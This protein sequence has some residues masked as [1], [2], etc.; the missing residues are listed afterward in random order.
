MNYDIAMKWAK[1]LESGRYTQG[2][3]YLKQ[4]MH[5]DRPRLCCLGV[6]CEMG[7][8]A[9]VEVEIEALSKTW[10]YDEQAQCL[11]LSIREWSGVSSETGVFKDENLNDY[12]SLS[13]LNDTG[14]KFSD[15]AKIIREKW[16]SL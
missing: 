15:I 12:S 14:S 3:Y 1:E 8:D 5:D 13:T 2:M 11:P 4:M 6:L 7:A 10:I 16:K 9:G